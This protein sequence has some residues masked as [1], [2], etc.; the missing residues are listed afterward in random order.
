MEGE[1]FP[2]RDSSQQDV[3]QPQEY[4]I[5]GNEYHSQSSFSLEMSF[6][7]TMERLLLPSV[8]AA[9]CPMAFGTQI[10]VIGEGA[11]VHLET[12][13]C[14]AVLTGE[15]GLQRHKGGESRPTQREREN[16]LLKGFCCEG[17]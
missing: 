8:S 13:N 10:R 14:M 17:I 3:Q 15:E 5:R 16:V 4:Q 6:S 9:I 12:V 1:G 7:F 2:R 11:E